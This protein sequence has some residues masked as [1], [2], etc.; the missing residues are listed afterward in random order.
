[1]TKQ[2]RWLTLA[3]ASPGLRE[4]YRDIKAVK[5]DGPSFCANQ[6][7]YLRFKPRLIELVG[8]WANGPDILRTD[9]AYDVAYQT[10]YELLP[11][12]RDCTWCG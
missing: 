11:D 6:V 12:C 5:D 4:L 2:V 10:L 3:A 9:E 1:M 8:Y 7:W